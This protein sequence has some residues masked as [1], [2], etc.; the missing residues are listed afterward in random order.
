MSV[1][2]HLPHASTVIPVDVRCGIVLD[3]EREETEVE[4]PPAARDC[5]YL[6]RRG[7]TTGWKCPTGLM[8]QPL[9]ELVS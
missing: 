9:I 4:T 2:L 6:R 5:R 1:I 7:A 8:V 3:P